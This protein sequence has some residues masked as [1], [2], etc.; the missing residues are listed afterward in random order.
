MILGCSYATAVARRVVVGSVIALAVTLAPV[1]TGMA[2]SDRHAI[3]LFDAGDYAGA[4]ADLDA[5]LRLNAKD[6]TALFYMGRIALQQ[7][8]SGEAVDWLEKAIAADGGRAEYHLWLGTALGEEA[9]RA[10]RFRQ[11]FLSRRVRTEFGRAVA[12][13]PGSVLAHLGLMQVY[14]LLPGI[15]GGSMDRAHQQATVLASLSPLYGHLG[16]GFLAQREKNNALAEREY[17]AGI[18]AAPDSAAGYLSLGMLYQREGR[19]ADAFATYDRLLKRRPDEVAAHFHIGRIAAL[20]GL[21][22]DRGEQ[23]MKLWLANPPRD[24]RT[25]TLSGAHH[26]LGQ[27]QQKKGRLDAARAEYAEALRIYPRNREARASLASLP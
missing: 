5:V 8:R 13:D 14:S 23:S 2:Q 12:L 27:I 17:E 4:R 24:V 6:A 1:R 22:L 11:P 21:N 15:M 18:L 7:D 9:Q 20:S 26:R 25:A 16:A 10:S 19:W 3:A